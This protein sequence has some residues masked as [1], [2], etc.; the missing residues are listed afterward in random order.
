[1]IDKLFNYLPYRHNFIP[2]EDIL[3]V[4]FKTP[5]ENNKIDNIFDSDSKEQRRMELKITVFW[6]ILFEYIFIQLNEEF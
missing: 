1:M 6:P 3:V 5:D 2:N 4:T